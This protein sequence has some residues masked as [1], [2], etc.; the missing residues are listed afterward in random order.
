MAQHAK[1]LLLKSFWLLSIYFIS[2]QATNDYKCIAFPSDAHCLIEHVQYHPGEQIVLPTGYQHFRIGVAKC[3]GDRESNIT[4][5][6]STLYEA[7]HRPASIEM[8][9]VKLKHINLPVNLTHGKFSDNE[10]NILEIDH[11]KVY[12]IIYLDL[13]RNQFSNVSNV[14]AL[15]NLETLQLQ[16]NG[17]TIIDQSIF[18]PLVKLKRLDLSYNAIQS[19][20]WESLTST[21][22]HLDCFFCSLKS[23]DFSGLNLPALEYLNLEKND[24]HVLNVTE[25]LR[26]APNLKEAYLFNRPIL[27]SNDMTNIVKVLRER[28]IKYKHIG[29]DYC[30]EGEE[31]VDGR[32]LGPLQREGISMSALIVLIS[33]AVGLLFCLV[34]Y[35]PTRRKIKR[36]KD[37]QT[38]VDI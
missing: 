21:L 3:G 35:L 1:N 29:F 34:I 23:A 4:S 2:T 25:I 14:S 9:N 28:D 30:F 12:Q 19:I 32:C 37:M 26:A 31:Y 36:R 16:S 22:V 33:V 38:A 7:M 8:T 18:V 13:N 10:I 20:S 27:P 6:D 5:L 15:V 17:I 24:I 11:H